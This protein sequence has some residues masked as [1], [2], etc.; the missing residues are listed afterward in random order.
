MELIARRDA[1]YGIFRGHHWK[2]GII[3]LSPRRVQITT[4]DGIAQWVYAVATRVSAAWSYFS[5]TFYFFPP[6]FSSEVFS[7][8]LSRYFR[9]ER[10]IT[11][12][13]SFIHGIRITIFRTVHD[14]CSRENAS[15]GC[16][17]IIDRIDRRRA[18]RFI[19]N[20]TSSEHKLFENEIHHEK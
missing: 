20:G 9:S 1:A 6:R 17:P 13:L 12:L 15:V 4:D 10:G 7:F 8:S 5:I 18:E 3:Q 11:L 14:V 16:Y 2:T 19:N